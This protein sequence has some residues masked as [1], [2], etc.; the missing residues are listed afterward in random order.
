[1]KKRM[2][3][4]ANKINKFSLFATA[5]LIFLSLGAC[6]QANQETTEKETT[7]VQPTT[8]AKVVIEAESHVE[9]EG[10]V[11]VETEGETKYVVTADGDSWLSFDVDVPVAGRYQFELHAK[12]KADSVSAWMEDYIDNKDDRTYNVTG[13]VPVPVAAA[14]A[15]F[16]KL[17]RDGSP[18]NKGLHKMKLHLK[19]GS[20]MVDKIVFTLMK[21]HKPLCEKFIML[22]LSNNNH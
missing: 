18:L 5:L 2:F 16:G 20:A 21:E 12:T 13:S 19:G 3:F 17:T 22:N 9:A 15:A 1:M 14:D 11:K 7:E 4:V 6:K 10:E 8:T